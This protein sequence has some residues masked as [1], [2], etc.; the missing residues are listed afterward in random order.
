MRFTLRPIRL[1]DEDPHKKPLW[2]G[3]V[4]RPSSSV[5]RNGCLP[6]ETLVLLFEAVEAKARDGIGSLTVYGKVC[7]NPTDER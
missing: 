1:R 2:A 4:A 7:E 6:H 5:V 3:T